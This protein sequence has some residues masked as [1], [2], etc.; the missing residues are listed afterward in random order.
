V[1]LIL[2]ILVFLIFYLFIIRPKQAKLKAAQQEQARITTGDRVLTRSGIYGRVNRISQ[3][4]AVVEVAPGVELVFD[5]RSVVKAPEAIDLDQQLSEDVFHAGFSDEDFN[6]LHDHL[7]ASSENGSSSDPGSPY[8]DPIEDSVSDAE[9]KKIGPD[10][11]D[12]GEQR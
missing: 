8:S 6:Q 4:L 9:E 12:L 2:P 10:D 3:D 5:R 1:S 7:E 11:H